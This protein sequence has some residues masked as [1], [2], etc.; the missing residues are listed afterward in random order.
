[1][2]M[3][4][5]PCSTAEDLAAAIARLCD[6]AHPYHDG[7]RARCPNHQGQSD[8]SLS[9]DPADDKIILTCFGGCDP[10]A[11]MDAVGL[12]LADLF[13]KRQSSTRHKHIVKVYD[14]PDA[15]GNLLH[16]TVRYE[17]KDFRQRRPDPANPGDYIWNLKGIEPVLYNLPTVLAAIQRGETIYL[18]EGEKDADTVQA[19]GLTATTNPM[20]ASKSTHARSAK[21]KWRESYTTT[22]SGADVVL[23][24]DNDAE[25][26]AHMRIVA[27]KLSGQARR[28][29]IVALPDLPLK[30]DISDWL[31]AGHTR[32]EFAAL[33]TAAR[34]T[35]A[36][37]LAEVEKIAASCA[38]TAAGQT[39]DD[40]HQRRNGH[41]PPSPTDPSASPVDTADED[42]PYSDAYN[43]LR[44]VRTHGQHMRYCAPWHSWLTWCGTHWQ[45]DTMGLVIRWQRETVKALGAQLPDLDDDDAKKLMGHIKSSL[46]TARLK[47]AV[48]QAHTWEGMTI[49]HE[50][51][52]ADPWLLNCTNG[53]IDLRTGT[54]RDHRQADL[55]TK[56][57]AIP[58]EAKATC[59]T[60]DAFLWRIMGGS[61]GDDDPAMSAGELENRRT[62]DERARA[63]IGFLQR[64]IG[65]SLTGST[66][67]QCLFILHGPTK[68]GKSTFLATLRALLGP[69]GQQ[70]DMESFMHKDKA[71]VR[72]DLADLA[73]AR[74]VCALEAQEGKRLAENLVK[75][76]TGGADVLK[77]RFLYEEHFTFKPQFKIFLGTNH[78]PKIGMDEAVWERIH[79]VPFLVQIPK[80]ERKKDLEEQLQAELPGILAWAVRGCLAWHKLGKLDEPPAVIDATTGYRKEMDSLGRFLDDCCTTG[81]AEIVKVKATALAGAYQTWCKRTG[82]TPLTNTAFIADLETRK[83]RRERGHANQYYWQ[84]LGL[85]ASDDERYETA[86]KED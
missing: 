68:T 80:E 59:P 12:T 36:P 45:R 13:L 50:A 28:V 47:A 8:T 1:M 66:R 29:R 21:P 30:G 10:K 41:A 9:I 40:L 60:W 3:T 15:H 16:Q 85:L 55:L 6:D 20:G 4:L 32:E 42:Y 53:T 64:A 61:Q 39:R 63:L 51:L 70:A 74:F 17:P 34:T 83:Y 62:A 81:A 44:L 19:L 23:L 77:A 58:Y 48:E 84:G 26:Q 76:M 78:L 65:Y 69:Y 2:T 67:E 25:G 7:W 14:Y 43:A 57:L 11:V 86:K 38:A 24:P 56:C 79:Q 75:Q 52:D 35:T 54:R 33:V 71:E 5:P 49:A 73:G 31:K 72:N 46:N 22:L 82:E 37:P 18:V 27:Q